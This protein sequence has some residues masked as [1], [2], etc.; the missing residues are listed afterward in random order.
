MAPLDP[1][2]A[3]MLDASAASVVDLTTSINLAEIRNAYR[4]R[5]R[6][7]SLARPPGIGSEDMLADGVPIR[8]YTPQ[9]AQGPLPLIVYLHGGGFVLG[10]VE[11]YDRQN[12]YLAHAANSILAFVDYRLAPEH[13]FP[14]AFHDVHTALDWI[15]ANPARIGSS[16][17]RIYLAGDSAGGNLAVN[18]ALTSPG[19]YKQLFLFYPWLDFRPYLGGPS[20]DS[21]ERFGEGYGLQT[22]L[23]CWFSDQYCARPGMADDPRVSPILASGLD[24]LPPVYIA[25]PAYDPLKDAA[26]AFAEALKRQSIPTT[27]REFDGLIHNFLGHAGVSET[28]RCALDEISK[29][30]RDRIHST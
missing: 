13:P 19:R 2:I 23:M 27:Y 16:A 18:A 12:A 17:D 6:S 14:A 5:Y 1:D 4:E 8:V 30:V 26:R 24:G 11:A 10:D 3:N 29:T 28:A 9:Q 25:A 15:D 20:Y 21:V 7:R 22:E